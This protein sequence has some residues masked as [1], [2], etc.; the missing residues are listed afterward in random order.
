[1]LSWLWNKRGFAVLEILLLVATIAI[2]ASIVILAINPTKQFGETRNAQ[3][4]ADVSTLLNAVNQYTEDNN[5]F[6]PAS[7]TTSQTEICKTGGLC[8]GLIDLGVL[9]T[10]EKYL[11]SIPFDPVDSNTNGAGYEIKTDASGRI[12]IVAP[13]AELE[14]VISVTR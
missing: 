9:T 3:R 10:H 12:T 1:M 14:T 13:D 6:L 4:R 2:L 11:V 5:G 7:I 8:S